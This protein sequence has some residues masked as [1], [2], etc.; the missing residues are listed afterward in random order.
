MIRTSVKES[1]EAQMADDKR[2]Y[3]L[4]LDAYQSGMQGLIV[5]MD[6]YNSKERE[7]WNR[8]YKEGCADRQVLRR[9]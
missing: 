2:L 3:H 5:S 9:R 1:L 7:A 6:S 8:G 4:E